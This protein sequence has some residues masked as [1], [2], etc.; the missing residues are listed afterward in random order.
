MEKWRYPL[1]LVALYVLMVVCVDPRGDFPLND[2]WSFGMDVKRLVEQ[3]N[4]ALGRWTAMTLVAQVGW[5]ALFTW[6]F[7][8]SFTALRLSTLVLGLAGVLALYGILL[9]V[10][11]SRAVAFFGALVFTACPLFLPLA[12]SFMTDVPFVAVALIACL[13]LMQG[14]LFSG[15][16]I[17]SLAVLIR[18][19]GLAIPLAFTLSNLKNKSTWQLLGVVALP[20]AVYLIYVLWIQ[21]SIADTQMSDEKTQSLLAS[22]SNPKESLFNLINNSCA[23]LL[24]IGL[25]TLPFSC[26]GI[27]E[28]WNNRKYL[29]SNVLIIF[30][31]GWIAAIAALYH[32]FP[33]W[34][35]YLFNFGLG[36]IVL[37]DTTTLHLA[38]APHSALF[39]VLYV[40]FGV[41]GLIFL[42]KL[43]LPWKKKTLFFLL[44]PLFY[45]LPLALGHNF[46]RYLLLIVPCALI[47]LAQALIPSRAGWTLGV[48]LAIL[49]LGF[50]LAGTHDYLA[51][52]RARWQGLNELLAQGIPPEKID[53]GLEFNGLTLYDKRYPAVEGKSWWWVQ[54]DAYI[55]TMGPIPGY[56]VY[57]TYPYSAWM[58]WGNR[59]IYMMKRE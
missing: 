16:L 59:A 10:Q 25:F 20:L 29:I 17:A 55:V 48:F 2:D 14:H 11:K 8:F 19:V 56:K 51:W 42:C 12:N 35:N 23:A 32:L 30:I 40:L 5:G 28:V 41:M 43:L 52:N 50:S 6:P 18:Q 45:F 46:D 21:P 27:K 24:Y 1:V 33:Y 57:K 15:S 34:G 49:Y 47:L 39:W 9:Q 7:G 4:L 53:G 38:H 36:A 31:C 22:L 37:Y 3:G 26:L 58:P 54:D 44:V 13:L